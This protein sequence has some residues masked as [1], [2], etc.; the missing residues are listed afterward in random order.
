MHNIKE[1]HDV[2]ASVGDTFVD[3]AEAFKKTKRAQTG[4]KEKKYFCKFKMEAKEITRSN[5]IRLSIHFNGRC[6]R[7]FQLLKP[8]FSYLSGRF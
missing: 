8:I 3:Y 5:N 6:P 4:K 2:K 1:G 7:P